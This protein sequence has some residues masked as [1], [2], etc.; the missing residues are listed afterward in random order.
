MLS[1]LRQD[2]GD[3]RLSA[4]TQRLLML[5]TL[6][7]VQTFIQ[8]HRVFPLK[9]QTVVTCIDTLNKSHPEE[10]SVACLV[11]GTE[12][13]SIYILD[14]EAFTIMDSLGLPSPPVLLSVSGLYDVEFRIIVAC[15]SGELCVLKRGWQTAKIITPLDS[16]PVGLVRRD[17][18]ITVATMDNTLTS[19]NSK[20]KKLWSVKMPHSIL[21]IEKMDIPG[22]GLFLV[23]VALSSNHVLIYNDKT[24]VDCIKME[25]TV[26]A[27]RFGRFGREENTLVIVT[28]GGALNM[29]ILKRTAHFDDMETSVNPL[30]NQNMKL[31]IPK[32][33]KLFVDQTLRE[34]E[35]CTLM[36]RVFQHDL[37]QLR[38]NTAR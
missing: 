21:C 22:R 31:N 37:Y 15:R 30:N 24:V 7:E 18:N 12:S 19:I 32:K 14:P 16:Q 2:V 20:G 27:M 26:S 4:R 10:G 3:T 23:A 33:T 5:E 17:K 28:I 29:K 9:R 35:N 36:H 25:D 1:S 38:L 34:R 13:S 6:S 11:L 8:T